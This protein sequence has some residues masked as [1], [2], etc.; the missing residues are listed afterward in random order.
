MIG[1]A[2]KGLVCAIIRSVC[3]TRAVCSY[4]V[5]HSKRILL[6]YGFLSPKRPQ[7][8]SLSDFLHSFKPQDLPRP[9][10][11]S[12]AGRF[13]GPISQSHR[14]MRGDQHLHLSS[15]PPTL[16]RLISHLSSLNLPT[17]MTN[18]TEIGLYLGRKGRTRQSRD[19][20]SSLISSLRH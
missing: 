5:S 4:K 19:I 20:A 7:V 11:M 9:S 14:I 2:I 10:L 6:L 16:D 18:P 13:G 3:S 12:G 15:R 17:K 1:F 8:S